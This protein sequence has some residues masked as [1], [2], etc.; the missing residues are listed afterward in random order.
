MFVRYT[1]EKVRDYNSKSIQSI[2]RIRINCLIFKPFSNLIPG[3]NS[4]RDFPMLHHKHLLRLEESQLGLVELPF[5]LIVLTPK[6]R[7][8]ERL[9]DICHRSNFFGKIMIDT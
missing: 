6:Y 9:M 4:R 2:G 5:S 1:R 7:V 8:R 3:R